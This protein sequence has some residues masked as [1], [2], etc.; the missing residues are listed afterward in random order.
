MEVATTTDDGAPETLRFTLTNVGNSTINLPRPSVD[1]SGENGVIVLHSIVRDTSS[2][3]G[4]GHG[5]SIGA[6]DEPTLMERVEKSWLHLRPGESLTFLGDC[7]QMLD[8]VDGPATYE[9]WAAYEPPKLSTVER[10]QLAGAG[11][12]VPSEKIETSHLT[13]SGQ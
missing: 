4:H 13:F 10:R 1:C 6:T 2:G 12:N 5:C 9:Y 11:Y 7:R 3:S 8:R